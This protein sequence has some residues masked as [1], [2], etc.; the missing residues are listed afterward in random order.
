MWRLDTRLKTH[1]SHDI[2]YVDLDGRNVKI[3]KPQLVHV[4]F[5]VPVVSLPAVL[6]SYSS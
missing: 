6:K 4:R 1:N 5:E 3:L 2:F